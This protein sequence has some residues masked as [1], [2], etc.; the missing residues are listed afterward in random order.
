MP[1]WLRDCHDHLDR[2]V[3]AAYGWPADI[4]DEELLDRLLA[5]NPERAEAPT[6]D[7]GRGAPP[8]NASPR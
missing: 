1:A 6:R 4:G 8:L 2:A 5:L 3:L 7:P